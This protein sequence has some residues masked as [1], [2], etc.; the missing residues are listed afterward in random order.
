MAQPPEDLKNSTANEA[1]QK[2]VKKTVKKAATKKTSQNRPAIKK[3]AKKSTAQKTTSKRNITNASTDTSLKNKGASVSV[4]IGPAYEN[5]T[6]EHISA[7]NSNISANQVEEGDTQSA[8]FT[9]ENSIPTPREQSERVLNSDPELWVE[10]AKVPDVLLNDEFV[11][12]KEKFSRRQDRREISNR[13]RTLFTTDAETGREKIR[14]FAARA[15]LRMMPIAI[16][17]RLSSSESSWDGWGI[18]DWVAV[19]WGVALAEW[20]NDSEIGVP[21]TNTSGQVPLTT[22]YDKA[23]LNAA[24][25]AYITSAAASAAAF[26]ISNAI[27]AT[28]DGSFASAHKP[29][30][31]AWLYDALDEAAAAATPFTAALAVFGISNV[32]TPKDFDTQYES[33]EALDVATGTAAKL[34]LELI[35]SDGFSIEQLRSS[36]LWPDGSPDWLSDYPWQQTIDKWLESLPTEEKDSDEANFYRRLKRDYSAIFN[37]VWSEEAVESVITRTADQH[38]R[39]DEPSSH[40]SL[41]RENLVNALAPRLLEYDADRES[42]Q[43]DH[44]TI[45][46]LGDWGIGKSSVICQLKQR[47]TDRE[48]HEDIGPVDY[49]FGEFNAWSYEHA[50]NIQAGIAQEMMAALTE[51]PGF[52]TGWRRWVYKPQVVWRYA[53]RLHGKRLLMIAFLIALGLV[54]ARLG[55]TESGLIN[56]GVFGAGALG[57]FVYIL[58]QLK[59]VSTLPLAQEFKS[60]LRLPSYQKYLG[61]IPEMRRNIRILC[62]LC[63]GQNNKG[64]NHRRLL[65]F[66]D[67]LDRCGVEGIV[68]TLEAVRLVLDIPNVN[69]V[70]AMDQR[71]ALPALACHYKA[72]SE[73][74]QRDPLSIAR[75]YLA[76]VIHLPIR[77]QKPDDLGVASYLARLWNDEGFY[78][79]VAPVE[80]KADKEKSND[81]EPIEQTDAEHEQ[82]KAETERPTLQEMMRDL[83]RIDV[84]AYLKKP[85]NKDVDPS[86]EQ[87]FNDQQKL[88]FYQGLLKFNLRNPR[89]IKRL[90]NSYNLLWSIYAHQWK[91]D[92]WGIYLNA[93]LVLEMINEHLRSDD[94]QNTRD[95]IRRSFFKTE[96]NR[97]LPA[98]EEVDKTDIDDVRKQLL[99][100]QQQHDIDLL[101]RLEPFV[102]PAIS[103]HYEALQDPVALSKDNKA[104]KED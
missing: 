95:S 67:D 76:K 40:D 44:L 42:H 20:V 6:A 26:A 10:Q 21:M 104:H 68:K 33:S 90:Y 97:V 63:L 43:Q 54:L 85:Q 39:P 41:G 29:N 77:L 64:D 100:F 88:A 84:S 94:D 37:G 23:V 75:D 50:D 18:T 19:L 58:Y 83:D 5:D 59:T 56:G 17:Q 46:L 36:P 4:A 52:V 51:P 82:D 57:L 78:Q 53:L 60:Y 81:A 101:K 2:V 71:V 35:E 31:I 80:Q 47:L 27:R 99:E 69:V 91:E 55:L 48:K 70:I 66:I 86:F 92:D 34:D 16:H 1:S 11:R 61:T 14:I 28:S 8:Q 30:A 45:G 38:T 24:N 65:Y 7:T 74:H 96:S 9:T 13:L 93:L 103:P 102:L 73:F 62:E 72:M 22:P 87:G 98:I 89:Q 12:I 3:S 25:T 79:R 15:A 32:S 49:L